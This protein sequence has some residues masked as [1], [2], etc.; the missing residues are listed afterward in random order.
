MIKRLIRYG[1]AQLNIDCNERSEVE[2]TCKAIPAEELPSLIESMESDSEFM[3]P[4]L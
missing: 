2:D 3:P 1:S 4:A